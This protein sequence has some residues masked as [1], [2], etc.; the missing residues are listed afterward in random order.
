VAFAIT[1]QADFGSA[2]YRGREAPENAVYDALNCLVDDEGQLF[3]RGGSEYKSTD[4]AGGTLLGLFDAVLGGN[5]RTT[6][7]TSALFG[8][9]NGSDA[10]TTIAAYTGTATPHAA[11]RPAVVADMMFS[12]T[13][14]LLRV[15]AYGG[16]L[17]G[18]GDSGTTTVTAGSRTV[19]GSGTTWAGD[20]VPGMI[21]WFS[22]HRVGVVESVVSNT[23]L[24]LTR[25]WAYETLTGAINGI[26]P[27]PYFDSIL[28]Y[29]TAIQV[30][31]H[32]GTA[33]DRLLLSH[34]THLHFS[35]PGQPLLFDTISG[36][37]YHEIPGLITGVEGLGDTALVFT[38]TGTCRVT[39][40][41]LDPL[42]DFGNIQHVVSSVND[43]VLW[44][45]MG[46]AR[47]LDT[48]V[49]PGTD[50]VYL[51]SPSGAAKPIA[52]PI[53]ALYLSYVKAG[54]QPGTA[55]VHRNHYFLPILNGTTLVDVLVCR[56]DRGFAW[57]RWSGHG[58]GVAYQ[59]R[60]GTTTRTP[61]LFSVASQRVTELTDAWSPSSSNATEADGTTHT[62]TIDTRDYP[63]LGGR[64]GSTT[65]KLRTRYECTAGATPTITAS[66]SRGPE[67]SAYSALTNIK[68]GATSDGL[69]MS[70]WDVVKQAPA[71][72]FRLTSTSAL[73]TF[74]LRGIEAHYRPS[75]KA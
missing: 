42:D 72:R 13:D 68:G 14:D 46:I 34:G 26:V 58:A 53:K 28:P 61:K 5:A 69:D 44:G 18:P 56:L 39:N 60:I 4:N 23:E 17:S 57:T 35:P 65:M 48:P 66:Y 73:S 64:L 16:A 63:T 49:V 37:D 12:L 25:P 7:W 19:S 71:I 54:Y 38:T 62:L 52:A 33:A 3:K 10:S 55:T 41:Y 24:K 67:G 75:G 21:L 45:E 50:N 29:G 40:L 47:W 6:Y 51:M 11:R 27:R 70:V 20:V 30:W 22:N 74:T 15:V 32:L 8:V 9:L 59:Q 36:T 43:V 31:G 2:I 1:G